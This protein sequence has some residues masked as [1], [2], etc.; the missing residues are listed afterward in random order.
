MKFDILNVKA[1]IRYLKQ[2]IDIY[3]KKENLS[4]K[5]LDEQR[6]MEIELNILKQILIKKEGNESGNDN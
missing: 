6:A 1:Q 5:E 2:Q 4:Q 3:D